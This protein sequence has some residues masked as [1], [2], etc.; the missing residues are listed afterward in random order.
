MIATAKGVNR[1][2][3]DPDDDPA[4][5][6]GEETEEAPQWA[7]TWAKVGSELLSGQLKECRF[8]VEKALRE[9]EGAVS[10]KQQ[11][12]SEVT[13]EQVRQLRLALN[14][15]RDHVENHLAPVAGVE[16]WEDPPRIP[17]G[18]LYELTKHPSVE[19]TDERDLEGNDE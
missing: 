3:T 4:N 12:P 17:M 16:P 18:K 1:A 13:P 10:S 6:Q 14:R 11:G 2:M 5:D 19:G 9:V 8:E 7:V 15:T